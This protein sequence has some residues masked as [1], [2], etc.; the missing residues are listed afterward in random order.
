MVGVVFYRK[1]DYIIIFFYRL[2]IICKVLNYNIL[3]VFAPNEYAFRLKSLS[4][5]LLEIM[6]IIY[7]AKDKRYSSSWKGQLL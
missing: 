6:L 5:L 2:E 1:G 4:V 7:F 3:G